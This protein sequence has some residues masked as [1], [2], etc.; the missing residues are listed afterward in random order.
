MLGTYFSCWN[1]DSTYKWASASIRNQLTW[2]GNFWTI[3]HN[4]KTNLSRY[5]AK[6]VILSL[7]TSSLAASMSNTQSMNFCSTF[8][9]TCVFHLKNDTNKQ[10]HKVPTALLYSWWL[11]SMN[12]T[13]IVLL[14]PKILMANQMIQPELTK[15]KFGCTGPLFG[16]KQMQK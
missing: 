13:G 3:S 12:Y 14:P 6:T 10:R 16:F 15:A 11:K 5:I 4:V 2:R 7:C 9:T 8:H 1:T